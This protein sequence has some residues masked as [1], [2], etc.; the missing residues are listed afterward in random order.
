MSVNAADGDT[1]EGSARGKCCAVAGRGKDTFARQI[2]RDLTL[3]LGLPLSARALGLLF[4]SRRAERRHIPAEVDVRG[5]VVHLGG[6]LSEF[7]SLSH[8]F[9]CDVDFGLIQFTKIRNIDRKTAKTVAFIMMRRVASAVVRAKGQYQTSRSVYEPN[10][11]HSTV[12]LPAIPSPLGTLFMHGSPS[13]S[14]RYLS[15]II[16]FVNPAT[17]LD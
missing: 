5:V 10:T 13:G 8:V 4:G 6:P 16:P 7:R 12:P 1:G 2:P 15:L 3:Q 11:R 9:L 14:I 17:L